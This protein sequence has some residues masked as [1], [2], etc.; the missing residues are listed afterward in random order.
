MIQR[1]HSWLGMEKYG[2][3]WHEEDLADELAEYHEEQNVIK[4]WSEASDVVYTCTRS[5]W[6]GFKLEFPLGRVVYVLGVVYMLPK[7]TLR[8]WFFKRAGRKCGADKDVHEVRN[9]KKTPK[10]HQIAK[11]NN[12]DPERF[13]KICE[14]QLRYWLLLP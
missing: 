14:K 4:K 13:Q 5:R 8:W 6:S 1:W 2:R 7:Y 9:P 12:L 11:R 3:A 10:L